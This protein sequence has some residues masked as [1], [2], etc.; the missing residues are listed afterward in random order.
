MGLLDPRLMWTAIFRGQSMSKNSELARPHGLRGSGGAG[1]IDLD[2]LRD[3]VDLEAVAI[4]L[5]GPAPGRRGQTGGRRLWWHCPFHEDKN[6]SFCVTQRLRIWR[7]FGCGAS[8]DAVALVMKL[9]S[10]A[11][12]EAIRWLEERRGAVFSSTLPGAG[13]ARS[14][15]H[16]ESA[17]TIT[18]AR[19]A[20]SKQLEP[21][22]ARELVEAAARRLW[23]PHGREALGA[24]YR[25]GLGTLAIERA[26]LGFVPVVAELT[27]RPGG[28]VIPWFEGDK[29]T[30]VKIRQRDHRRPKYR[31][32]YRDGPRVFPGPQ[33]IRTD[34]PLVVVE[35]EF[36]AL[37]LG[38]ELDRHAAVV[39]LGSASSR[40]DPS[41][42]DLILACPSWYLATDRDAAGNQAAAR[43]PARAKRVLPPEPHKDWTEAFQAGINL[44][45]FWLKQLAVD[46]SS[47]VAMS[48]GDFER[49]ERAAIM[50]YDGGLT[51]E[52]AERAA[53]LT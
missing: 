37:L 19:P 24:L 43:W 16:G 9:T 1:W 49:E 13:F 8:G 39:T 36:D 5:L 38:Q 47:R 27:D 6:P 7:C 11:F 30:L 29:L 4:A 15:W 14:R 41:L 26:R 42:S 51:R 48:P 33:T 52:A 53:G 21:A 18:T 44:R 40:L 31:E 17:S 50:E 32:V 23:A 35:G 34:C 46:Q 20:P 25:R 2:A 12:L 45:R 10:C 3:R 22:T 28:I